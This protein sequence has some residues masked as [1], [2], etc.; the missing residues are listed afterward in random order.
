MKTHVRTRRART[1]VWA[2][3]ST[4]LAVL[5]ISSTT[6]HAGA[7]TDGSAGP[8]VTLSGAFTVPPALGTVAGG[9]RF[10]SFQNFSI[11]PGES[12]TFTT[13]SVLQNV[14][15]RVT[16]GVPSTLNGPLRLQAAGGGQPGLFFINPAG[17]TLGAGSSVDVPGAL[18]L[19]TANYLKLAD[20]SFYQSDPAKGSSFSA[21]APEAF[22]FLGAKAG[23]IV[24]QDKVE[25][26][27]LGGQAVSLTAGDITLNDATMG[28]VGGRLGLVA[29]GSTAAEFGLTGALPAV[30]GRLVVENSALVLLISSRATDAGEVTV[31]AGNVVIGSPSD[32]APTGITSLGTADGKGS[33]IRINAA[34]GLSVQ[35]GG[36]V[37]AFAQ[38]SANAGNV[39]ITVGGGVQLGR[40]GSIASFSQS[41]GNAGAVKVAA[42]GAIVLDGGGT[43]LGA[44][45][46][47]ESAGSGA[48]GSVSVSAGAGLSLVNGGKISSSSF[49]E[50]LGG[51]VKVDAASLMVDNQGALGGTG[52]AS[53]SSGTGN[54]G[55]VEVK[56]SGAMTLINGGLIQSSAFGA[57]KAGAV[58]VEAGSV[59]LRGAGVG[60]AVKTGIV[61]EAG[62]AGDA[63]H[64]TVTAT[65]A[66]AIQDGARISSSS[67]ASGNAGA[68]KVSSATLTLEGARSQNESS[69]I[70]SISKQTGQAGTVDVVVRELLSITSGLISTS[71]EGTGRGGSVSVSAGNVAISN[72][73]PSYLSGI[74]SDTSGAGN[75]GSVS[76]T[77]A[78]SVS[79]TGGGL[80][81]S[82]TYAEGAAG[83]VIVTAGSIQLNGAGSPF[84][85]RI[86]SE[87][88]GSGNAG[89]VQV[90]SRGALSIVNQA[91]ITSS[92]Y[93]SGNAGLVRVQ[94][95]SITIDKM[96]SALRTGIGSV[97]FSGSGN[98]GSVDVTANGALSMLNGG[99]ISSDTSAA[100]AAGS[101]KV[102]AESIS[103]LGGSSINSGAQAGS[104]GQT[105]NVSVSASNTL[106][107]TDSRL[108]IAN[109]A[110][111][112]QPGAVLPSRLFVAAP[113]VNLFNAEVTASASGNIA[114]SDIV[115]EQTVQ[116]AARDRS[117]VYT[118]A[119]TG[120]GGS[121]VLRGGGG[122]LLDHSRVTTSITGTSNG[123][124]GPIRIDAPVIV[125]NTGFVQANTAVANARGGDVSINVDA[126]GS[127][128]IASGQQLIS[129]GRPVR[130]QPAGNAPNVIQAARPDGV[131]GSLRVASPRIDLSASLG[132]L[133]A[134]RLDF[135]TLGAD[136]CRVGDGSSLTPV[137]RGG[138]R[139]AHSERVRPSL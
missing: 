102:S 7:R 137:G 41:S 101:V 75:A 18:H 119:V 2:A 21:A 26:T 118:S 34:N 4:V 62:G 113:R 44:A 54:A 92:A 65:G 116:L 111:V 19:S 67:F 123:D 47:S 127:V 91:A 133:A 108:S 5:A 94:A 135:G 63:G 20:G 95:G 16:G 85:T 46:G 66:M 90:V 76:V 138:L 88:A 52:I 122:L 9:N 24:L 112:A 114:A 8:V 11:S 25:L 31:V 86:A 93:A 128:L 117:A 49:K 139:P 103:L 130:F 124:G 3:K 110:T 15:A 80:V 74:T 78:D 68:V 45:I 43:G 99:E 71:T 82:S 42:V 33:T 10:H 134:P 12:A 32:A 79:L 129:G 120:R 70:A 131:N 14:I 87:T 107:L 115:I 109:D 59:R 27:L 23:A 6:L 100:G 56:V 1:G 106:A 81:S 126:P 53:N 13:S 98:G 105:G 48:S 69:T 89:S 84:G 83:A 36:S 37:L 50:G 73:E 35:G 72:A 17:I 132:L 125:L 40:G 51:L 121:I 61:S 55:A 96:G 57:G 39:D 60:V 29:V 104:S 136:L 77:A 58:T 30:S 38:Q 97:A 64:V 22:G 28:L